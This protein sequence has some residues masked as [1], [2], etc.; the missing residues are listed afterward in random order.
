MKHKF[1]VREHFYVHLDGDVHGPGD[2]V[3]LTEEQAEAH[4]AQ[5]EP[6]GGRKGAKDRADAE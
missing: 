3:E 4:A 2:V 6:L 5:I 1:K